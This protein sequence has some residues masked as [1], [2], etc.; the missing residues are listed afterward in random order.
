MPLTS[1]IS[2][3]DELWPEKYQQEAARLVPIFGPDLLAIHHIGST[4][5][6]GLSAKPEIDVLLVMGSTEKLDQWTL[7]LQQIGY[8]RGGDLRRGHHFFKRDVEGRR[9]HKLHLC[10]GGHG[11]IAPLL[12]FRDHLRVNAADRVAYEKLKL[13]LEEEN[14]LGIAEYLDGK[15]PFIEA[16]LQK[17]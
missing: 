4:A 17:A 8:R 15:T 9:T 2:P 7:S 12:Q 1:S 6:P 10:L 14:T 13:T 5:V 3:Y 11:D 16:V